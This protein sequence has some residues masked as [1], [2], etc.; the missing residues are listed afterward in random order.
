[1]RFLVGVY[2]PHKAGHV[3]RAF[4]SANA[5]KKRRS[6]FPTNEWIMD[7]GAF[8]TIAQHGGYPESVDAYAAIIDR[9][10]GVGRLRRA[11]AQDFMCEPAML[12]RTG[13]GHA[14]TVREHQAWTIDRYVQ[15][16]RLMD[17][18]R[19]L[20]MPVL[21]GYAPKDYARHVRA[22]GSLLARGAWVGVGSVCKRQGNPS[23]I[24]AVL[25]A[26]HAERGDLRLHG[27][28]VKLTALGDARV[29]DQ[30][31]SADSMAWSFAARVEGRDPNDIANAVEYARRVEGQAVQECLW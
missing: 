20:I 17:G 2:H 18:A 22:Y 19:S 13:R 27:F 1:M 7:S 25:E 26:I 29:R 31:Y 30:L 11:V 5:L 9:F 6:A 15:L 8:T 14:S 16:A 4:V 21:Q 10:R 12:E 28:G 23:A 24:A 3:A